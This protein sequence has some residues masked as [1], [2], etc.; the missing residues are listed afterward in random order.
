MVVSAL[1]FL[2]ASATAPLRPASSIARPANFSQITFVANIETVG[3]VVTG[4]NLPKSADL[5][6]RKTGETN[7][8]HGHPLMRIG[9]G[10][11]VGS[12]FGLSA[13][14]TYEVKVTDGATEI[15]GSIT[16]QP[17]ELPF[18]P[19]AILHVNDDSPP[20]GN[21]SASAPFNTIQEAVN[22]AGPGT[23]I[24]VADGIY[25]ES[26]SFPT[27]GTSGNWIQVKAEGSGAILDGA[28][29][30][31]GNV[32]TPVEGKN[33]VWF[34]KLGA[35]IGYLARDGR[36]YYKYDEYN[37]LLNGAGHNNV[38]I[39]EGWF[40][41]AATLKLFVRSQDDP[42]AHT[43]QAPRFNHAFDVNGRD[44]IWIEGFEMRFFGTRTDGCGVC[45]LN[46]SH[47]VIRKNRIRNMQLGVF[48]NW[49]GSDAQGNDTRVEF[50]E[51]FDPLVN[52]WPWQAV[53]GSS[54]EGTGIVVRGHRGAIVRS[55]DIHNFF[56]GIYTGISGTA[57]TNPAISFDAD[58]YRNHI[59][60]ISDDGLEPEGACVNIRFRDNT[61]DRMLAGISL[62]PITVG[63]V[64]VIRNELSNFTSKAFK[65]DRNSDGL[66]LVYHNSSWTNSPDA[67]GMEFISPVKNTTLRNNI[68]HVN[69]F[70]IIEKPTGSL[71]NDWNNDNWHNTRVSSNPHFKW[72]N[73]N[74][75]RIKDLCRG[76][77]FECNGHDGDPGFANPAGGNLSLLATS[78]NVDRGV[79]I[80]GI[81]DD[82]KGAAPDL[83]A[84]EFS[85]SAPPPPPMP[86]VVSIARADANPTNTAK[87]RFRVTFTE[88]VTGVD[89]TAP[90]TDF[91]L[92]ASTGITGASISG[93][94][95]ESNTSY[96]VQVNTGSGDGTLQLNLNDDDSIRNAAGQPLGGAGAGN[97]N[98]SAGEIYT[99]SKLPPYTKITALFQS[100]GANDGWVLESD[101]NSNI[102]G[103]KN[104]S[105][106]TFIVG[107][108]SRNRQYISILQFST[109]S[110]P[111]NAVITNVMLMVRL[112]TASGTNP[113]SVLQGIAVDI[114]KGYFGSSGLFGLNSL[115][116]GDFQS[117]ASRSSIGLIR[118]NPIQDWYWAILDPAAYPF[119][120]LTGVTEFRLR[121]QIDDNNDRT[122]NQAAFYSGNYSQT[123]SR[124]IL[125]VDYYVP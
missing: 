4:T 116:R 53:K 18:N 115:D 92:I 79:L 45:T 104:A 100:V 78:L 8:R 7:W 52:E 38:T 46:S 122:N 97:G 112:Q 71:N 68:F 25:H 42:A 113:F 13:A 85:S 62:A 84:L 36:R 35:P 103:T 47:V 58:V 15:S 94:A 89:A 114:R 37:G 22:G 39:R 3:V 40:F 66:V 33:N 12:L 91:E 125:Q 55:N 108:D 77:G 107:D 93:V 48:V 49:N 69:G 101:E 111:D 43:W 56:N 120:N 117:A 28:D 86:K 110:M 9:D 105:E 19:P 67:S 72:E 32:W 70:S 26:I 24:L 82:F 61:I 123:S 29:T 106:P 99:V 73:V 76:A 118:N 87:V 119:V 20:G 59:R 96:L 98:F 14:A 54:M 51:I 60:D 2:F 80:P 95:T 1:L 74:Y 124:P 31:S 34:T 102:G 81:N 16:T 5:L 17:D 41:E 83:G 44:W 6:Y 109:K 57:G 23:Q 30:L 64:W 27:S 90:F 65:W 75:D 121:F 21:G 50:N 63:P 11:L 10:R 88:T